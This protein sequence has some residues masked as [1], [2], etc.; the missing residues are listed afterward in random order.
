MVEEYLTT[1]RTSITYNYLI[2]TYNYFIEFFIA[3]RGFVWY[4]YKGYPVFRIYVVFRRHGAVLRELLEM[5]C[6]ELGEYIAGLGQPRYR[7]GQIMRW[8]LRGTEIPEMT[9]LSA[10][11]RETLSREA[12]TGLPKVADKLVSQRDGTV[13]YLFGLSDGELVESVVMDYEHG[14]S[15]CVS[16]QAGCRMGCRF[17]ASTLRGLS[18]GL[19]AGE[20][21]GQVIVAQRESGERVG[22]VVVMGIGEPFDN[23]D[24]VVRFLRLVSAPEG[25]N[26]GCRHISVSTCGVVDGIRKLAREGLQVTLSVS[27]HSAINVVRSRIMPVNNKWS[28]EELLSACR[29]YFEVTGR[30]ISFEYILIAGV[31]DGVS[32]AAV[33]AGAMGEYMRGVPA[34]VNLIPYNPVKEREFVSPDRDVVTRFKAVLE[35]KGVNVTGTAQ[36]RAGH[37][38]LVRAAADRRG[39]ITSYN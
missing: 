1:C 17:C 18:R 2:Y 7:A 14:R 28:V 4:N 24:N 11:L 27:L 29:E 23:Y 38:R 16:S 37:Q 26:I 21:L 10:A 12:E 31:N 15:V 20:M 25:L 36:A 9:D 33:L 19:T 5:S 39:Q 8:L 30:R 22:G 34:H 3:I 13:K 35:R 6:P 32:D